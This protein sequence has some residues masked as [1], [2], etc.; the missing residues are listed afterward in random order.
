MRLAVHQVQV[1]QPAAGRARQRRRPDQRRRAGAEQ[2]EHP[3]VG[4]G[5]HGREPGQPMPLAPRVAGLV[6][7]HPGPVRRQVDEVGR[8]GAVEVRYAQ[9]GRVETGAEVRGG[10]H[11]HP[12]AEPAVAEVR[13]VADL[14]VADPRQ[15]GQ[16]VAG[17][18]GQEDRL[19]DLGEDQPGTVT[20]HRGRDPDARAEPALAERRVPGEPVA[21][22]DQQ[23][24][25]AVAAE[26]D[27]AHVRVVHVDGGPGAERAERL[28]PRVV[29]PLVEAAVRTVEDRQVGAAVAGQVEP[30]RPGRG[31][32]GRRAFL[33]PLRCGQH[34]PVTA[35]RAEVA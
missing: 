17:H 33:D 10:I 23:V 26:V 9:P 14:S 19:G 24:G 3:H 20:V 12:L 8:S 16:A 5:V 27:E 28:P 22:G 13:P 2:V 32:R 21:L 15:I 34:R 18:V 1:A 31:K 7:V 11:H 6:V 35:Q 30:A 25:Q 4:G 29:G